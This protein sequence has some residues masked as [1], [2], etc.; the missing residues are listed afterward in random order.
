MRHTDGSHVGPRRNHVRTKAGAESSCR[1]EHDE[2]E[3][4]QRH[5]ERPDDRGDAGR[6]RPAEGEEG[7]DRGDDAVADEEAGHDAPPG[8]AAPVVGA[9]PQPLGRGEAA[10]P[11]VAD[12]DEDEREQQRRHGDRHAT[13]THGLPVA[14]EPDGAREGHRREP[15]DRGLGR[16]DPADEGGQHDDRP[17][18][19]RRERPRTQGRREGARGARRCCLAG[20]WSHSWVLVGAGHVAPASE[21][22]PMVTRTRPGSERPRRAACSLQHK[23]RPAPHSRHTLE[24]RGGPGPSRDPGTE[25][26]PE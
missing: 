4:G 10:G 6:R 13:S 26:V 9:H 22:A 23:H 15:A 5:E 21:P 16:G 1:P 17:G 2:A 24:V 12:V 25:G 3:R 11:A 20:Q 19:D 18:A 8:D 7:E 14:Q